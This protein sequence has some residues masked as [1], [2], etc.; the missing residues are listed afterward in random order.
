MPARPQ[1][2]ARLDPDQAGMHPKTIQV[3]P[4]H[5]LTKTAIDLYGHLYEG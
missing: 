4:G 1:T 5:T 3:R 2:L